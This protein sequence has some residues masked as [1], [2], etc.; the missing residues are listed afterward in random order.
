MQAIAIAKLLIL[1]DKGEILLI[2]R[3]QTDVRRPGQWDLPGGRVEAAEDLRE[4]ALRETQEE[5]GVSITADQAHILYATSKVVSAVS[6]TWTFFACQIDHSPEVTLS[7]EHDEHQWMLPP[8]ALQ[9]IEYDLHRDMLTYVTAN[10]ILEDL[11]NH[12]PVT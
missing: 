5:V 6:V 9:E 2:R 4:A 8:Q 11:H 3:S 12:D 10:N 1:N 7:Y